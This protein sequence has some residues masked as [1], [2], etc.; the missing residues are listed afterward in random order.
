MPEVK[1]TADWGQI[2]VTSA[3][4]IPLSEQR[5]AV[6]S[7]LLGMMGGLSPE[8]VTYEAGAYEIKLHDGRK[9]NQTITFLSEEDDDPAM[10]FNV[11]DG[12]K[13]SEF[14][15]QRDIRDWLVAAVVEFG[16]TEF[17]CTW[18]AA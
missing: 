9:W 13:L 2:K 14:V 11:P 6:I 8:K 3:K 4:E 5:W 18:E 16:M 12:W 1:C 15:L 17:R 10:T 7:N